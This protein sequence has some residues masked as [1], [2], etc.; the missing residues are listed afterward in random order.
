MVIR[1]VAQRA[2][3]VVQRKAAV[4]LV[5]DGLHRHAPKH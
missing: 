1:R 2:F 3:Q 5:G 4:C